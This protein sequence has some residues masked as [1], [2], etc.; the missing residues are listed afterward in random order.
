MW[1]SCTRRSLGKSWCPPDEGFADA[2]ATPPSP[3]TTASASAVSPTRCTKRL[4]S[5]AD[6]AGDASGVF[7]I[8]W[9]NSVHASALK[10]QK[11]QLSQNCH[12]SSACRLDE[13]HSCNFFALALRHRLT[14]PGERLV[15]RPGA[16]VEGDQRDGD[17]GD[18]VGDVV[19]AE[20]QGGD[21]GQ[22]GVDPEDD[23]EPA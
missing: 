7:L 15:A 20:V 4:P 21:A 22:A 1:A 19:P 18:V 3:V 14:M 23:L 11:E 9:S 10:S 12:Y 6:A 2:A 8:T 16:D 5:V 17:P 13:L